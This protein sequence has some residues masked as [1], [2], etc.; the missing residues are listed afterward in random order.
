MEEA[1]DARGA[2]S[3]RR[4]VASRLVGRKRANRDAAADA[5]N[6]GGRNGG[7][8]AGTGTGTGTGSISVSHA[9]AGG[10]GDVYGSGFGSSR[11]R[12]LV[13]TRASIAGV[14]RAL[15]AAVGADASAAAATTRRCGASRSPA[16]ASLAHR[17]AARRLWR[18]SRA[19]AAGA[20]VPH[21][22]RAFV[23]R[24]RARAADAVAA[25]AAS[26]ADADATASA[27]AAAE[28]S[29]AARDGALLEDGVPRSSRGGGGGAWGLANA[30]AGFIL[31]AAAA[32][33]ALD[34]R[35]AFVRVARD[36]GLTR[37]LG[38]GGGGGATATR[39]R[40][41]RRRRRRC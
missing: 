5:T 22:P 29:R 11:P 2:D 33:P 28:D 7:A 25:V 32:A 20:L 38:G 15:A 41:R 26:G 37:A 9:A 19:C 8:S 14:F 31:A 13:S 30:I 1:N 6:V 17:R 10:G 16:P 21:P 40:R 12:R 18:I 36:G 23:A 27:A 35:D 34:G 3:V 4:A 39:R 24:V